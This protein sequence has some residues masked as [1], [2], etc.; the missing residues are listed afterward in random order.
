[1]PD[2][3]DPLHTWL[4]ISPDEQPADHYRLLGLKRFETNREVISH[5]ADQRMAHVRSFQQ[6]RHAAQSQQVLNDL[7]KAAGCLLNPRRKAMYD[8]H[9]R[10]TSQT[11]ELELPVVSPAAAESRGPEAGRPAIRIQ[12]QPP[13]RPLPPSRRIPRPN[14]AAR[15]ALWWWGGGTSCAVGIL[16]TAVWMLAPGPTP[17]RVPSPHVASGLSDLSSAPPALSAPDGAPVVPAGKLDGTPSDV[18][19]ADAATAVAAGREQL[20][21]RVAAPASDSEPSDGPSSTT[22]SSSTPRSSVL[23][24]ATTSPP[25][26]AAPA[27]PG[28]WA[29]RFGGRDGIEIPDSR[30]LIRW[31]DTWTVEMWLRFADDEPASWLCGNL[32]IG[33]NHAEVAGGTVAGW[34]AIVQPTSG[35][36]HR[37]VFSTT[38]G[39]GGDFPM[40]SAAWH[41]LAFASDEQ[42]L[43]VFVDGL[44]IASGPLAPLVAAHVASPLDLHVGWHPFL[45]ANQPAGFRGDLRAFRISSK[46]RYQQSFVPEVDWKVD[47]GTRLLWDFDTAGPETIADRS[48]N[49]RT[50]KLIGPQWVPWDSASFV[51]PATRRPSAPAV[52]AP[53]LPKTGSPPAVAAMSLAAADLEARPPVPDQAQQDEA[54]AQLERVAGDDIRQAK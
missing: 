16:A 2:A 14:R 23:P 19:S 4:G 15:P 46:C 10:S 25:R 38:A 47:D 30:D 17:S 33:P 50:G 44:R 32:V 45:H 7:A 42:R 54:R 22:Q 48:D 39:Y 3:F 13:V 29:L 24:V 34:Q 53:S 51:N 41:H 26:G 12:A 43:T 37:I 35:G 21:T 9:L 49:R 1:M 28:P 6:G 20:S 8:T 31:T 5:A 52:V 27:G 40:A 11:A 18:E 36:R